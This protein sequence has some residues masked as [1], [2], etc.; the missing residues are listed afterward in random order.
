MENR[1]LPVSA[2][3]KVWIINPPS[4]KAVDLL[5]DLAV[6]GVRSGGPRGNN[7]YYDYVERDLERSHRPLER[8][9]EKTLRK[10]GLD[11]SYMRILPLWSFGVQ[12]PG[13]LSPTLQ[14]DADRRIQAMSGFG[15]IEEKWWFGDRL[16]VFTNSKPTP[17]FL[18]ALCMAIG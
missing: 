14:E 9:V 15:T 5:R 11:K 6:K 18:R 10:Y 3:K 16:V 2:L 4:S 8:F 12:L 13:A 7:H 1:V 17:T